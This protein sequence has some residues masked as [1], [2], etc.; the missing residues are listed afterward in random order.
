[1]EE[2]FISKKKMN[3]SFVLPFICCMIIPY[4]RF[5]GRMTKKTVWGIY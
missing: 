4:A 5:Q 1:M 3:V 2:D